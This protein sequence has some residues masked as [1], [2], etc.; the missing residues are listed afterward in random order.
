MTEIRSA[1]MINHYHHSTK[2]YRR[3]YHLFVAI[4]IVI[5]D[6]HL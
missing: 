5:C 2:L 6:V 1:R 4:G 3:K